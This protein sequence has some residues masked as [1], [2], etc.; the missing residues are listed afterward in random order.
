MRGWLFVLGLG[1]TGGAAEV[2][3]SG[4]LEGEPDDTP[5]WAAEIPGL[6]DGV[7]ESETLGTVTAIF[8]VAYNA[9]RE[10]FNVFFA[11]DGQR[12]YHKLFFEG[13]TPAEQPQRGFLVVPE[14]IYA[15]GQTGG[16]EL[17]LVG[18]GTV[19]PND[20]DGRVNLNAG[21]VLVEGTI[22]AFGGT[23]AFR[24]SLERRE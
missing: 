21:T 15:E 19:G 13:V 8:E 17:V 1:C 22:S 3:D 12:A 20:R 9:R 16:A 4:L 2:E 14:Q 7:E 23:E 11:P 24:L 10:R 5:D 18:A 6:Y